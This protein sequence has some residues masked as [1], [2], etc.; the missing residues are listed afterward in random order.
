MFA[1]WKLGRA[2]GI[3]LYIHWTFWLLPLWVVLM[4]GTHGAAALG[5]NLAVLAAAFGCVLLHELGHAL[6]ARHYGIGTRDITLYPI[7]GVASLQR[8]AAKPVH[9]LWIT[10]AGP[11]VNFAIAVGLTAVLLILSLFDPGLVFGSLAGQFLS[12]LLAANVLMVVF[13]LLP[14]FPMDGGRILRSLLAMA[15]GHL[16]ATRVAV[17]VGV[18]MAALMGLVGALVLKSPWLMVIAFFVF[19]AGQAELQAAHFREH[20]RRLRAAEAEAVRPLGDEPPPLFYLRPN[21]TV[22]TWDGETG[23]WVKEPRGGTP[24]AL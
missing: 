16:Q 3:P 17:I 10:L 23:R 6:T 4:T 9:E 7:G 24:R 20:Q 13:N 19:V 14:A 1:S 15:V 22:Y 12:W 2:F 21:V 11:A 5:L 18:I 8:P